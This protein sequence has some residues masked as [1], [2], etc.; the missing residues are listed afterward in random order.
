MRVCQKHILCTCECVCACANIL[1]CMWLQLLTYFAV[2][3][4]SK[5]AEIKCIESRLIFQDVKLIS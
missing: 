4:S 3:E 1:I 2:K 5:L